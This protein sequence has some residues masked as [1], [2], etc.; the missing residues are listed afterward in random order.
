MKKDESL[1]CAC[2]EMT[3]S[4][5]FFVEGFE[6]KGSECLKCGKA[7]LNSMDLNNYIEFRKGA[8]KRVLC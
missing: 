7:F 4:K 5:S 8:D 2:G 3:K 1:R 6:I